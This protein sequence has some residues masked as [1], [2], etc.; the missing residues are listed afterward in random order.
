LCFEKVRQGKAQFE[1]VCKK[2]KAHLDKERLIS[3]LL[4]VLKDE[5]M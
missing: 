2:W 4:A 3:D 1:A 5:T